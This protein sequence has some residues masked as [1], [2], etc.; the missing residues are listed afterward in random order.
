MTATLTPRQRELARH[1]LGLDGRR[2]C[3]YRNSFVAGEDHEDYADWIAMSAG[4]LAIRR[5][6]DWFGGDD[7]FH[8]TRSGAELALDPGERLDEEDFG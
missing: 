6:E 4:G 5:V 1:A 2:K 7:L 8:L 3:S